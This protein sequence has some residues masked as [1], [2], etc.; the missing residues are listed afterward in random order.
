[1][2]NVGRDTVALVRVHRDGEA[3]WLEMEPDDRVNWDGGGPTEEGYYLIYTTVWL[4]ENWLPWMR[5]ETDARDCDGRLRTEE[6]SCWNAEYQQWENV[7]R[8]QRD[9]EAEKAGY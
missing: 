1:M 9:Y 5:V 4:D 7:K 8:S 3:C 2:M 6:L